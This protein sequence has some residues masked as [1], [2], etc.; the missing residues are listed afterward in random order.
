MG[1]VSDFVEQSKAPDKK[2]SAVHQALNTV[3]DTFSAEEIRHALLIALEDK[4]FK[5]IINEKL[6]SVSYEMTNKPQEICLEVGRDDGFDEDAVRDYLYVTC[7]LQPQDISKVRVINRKTFISVPQS[8]IQEC[9]QAMTKKSIA[10]GNPRIYI[11]EDT[12]DRSGGSRDF[13]GGRRD[14][15]DRSG[16]GEKRSWQKSKPKFRRK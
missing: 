6:A 15:R 2:L 11:V 9:M 12:F 16:R 7:N 3:I 14:R 8:R 4:F 10:K 1:A 13:A 5:D